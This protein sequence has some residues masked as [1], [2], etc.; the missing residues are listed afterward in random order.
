MF[1]GTSF[2][3]LGR[4][5][6]GNLLPRFFFARRTFAPFSVSRP[7][8]CSTVT[9]RQPPA[10]AATGRWRAGKTTARKRRDISFNQSKSPP[11]IRR[12][13]EHLYLRSSG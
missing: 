5:S 4:P 6:T 10:G 13:I 7:P 9:T 11:L 12:F 3:R 2:S 8:L 1:V